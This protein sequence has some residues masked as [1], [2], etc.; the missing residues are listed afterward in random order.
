MEDPDKK[1]QSICKHPL[2]D[3]IKEIE[4]M[5][6]TKKEGN[7]I[8]SKRKSTFQ[9]KPKVTTFLTTKKNE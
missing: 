7:P 8:E 9:K 4:T 3:L 1:R 5:M 6:F 2:L